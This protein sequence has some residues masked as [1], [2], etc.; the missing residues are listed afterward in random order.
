MQ[1]AHFALA[2]VLALSPLVMSGPALADKAPV[3]ISF[4]FNVAI[5]GYD[6]VAYFTYSRPDQGSDQFRL[7]YQGP[8]Y[9]SA[10]STN[11]DAFKANQA[12]FAPQFGGYCARTVSQGYTAGVDPNA[13]AIVG[14]RLDLNHNKDIQSIWY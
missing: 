4:G 2:L 7:S 3:W 13:W 8:E 5:E 12:R 14:G 10:S 1:G 9:C 11:R 6:P